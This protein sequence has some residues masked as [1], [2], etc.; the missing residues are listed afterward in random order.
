MGYIWAQNQNPYDFY[1]DFPASG[2]QR[3]YYKIVNGEAQVTYPS[4]TSNPWG[5]N[6][7]PMGSL[8]IPATVSNNNTDYPVTSIGEYAFSSCSSLTSVTIPN[9]VTS[10]ARYAFSNCTSLASVTIPS[11]VTSIHDHS[12]YGCSGL[13]SISVAQGNTTYDSRN[14][15]NA[16][17]KTSNNM[18]VVGCRNTNIPSTVTSIGDYAFHR[19]RGLSNVTI[20]NSVTTIEVQAFRECSGLERVTLTIRRPPSDLKHSM[21]APDSVVSPWAI[22]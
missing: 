16:I 18:L 17:I 6:T 9:S 5:V 22:R 15:C 10:I 7:R 8:E 1:F 20:P 4:T 2:G 12:F 19:R 13:T 21:G 11:S 14:N 3:L